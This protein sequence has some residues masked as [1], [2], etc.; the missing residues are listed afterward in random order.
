M[1]LYADLIVTDIQEGDTISDEYL[2]NLNDSDIYMYRIVDVDGQFYITYG[3]SNLT[4][5]EKRLLFSIAGDLNVNK[6][7]SSSG[8]SSNSDGVPFFYTARRFVNNNTVEFLLLVSSM[9]SVQDAVD[10]LRNQLIF[11]VVIVL[12]VSLFIS[13]LLADRISRPIDDM[14]AVAERWAKGDETVLFNGGSYTEMHE[15]ANA[16]N[17]AKTEIN[18]SGKLQRDL[19]ANVSHDLKTPLTMIKAYAEMIRD[20]S[21]ENK[22]KRDKHTQVIID[23]SDRLA[24]LV[25]DI[26]SLSKLQSQSDAPEHKIVNLSDLVETIIL[27]FDGVVLEKGYVIER[28]IDKGVYVFVD[29]KKIEEVVYNLIG[30]A[31]NYTGDDKTVKVFLSKKDNV[32]TLEIIDSGVGIS[33]DKIDTIWERYLRYS[34]THHRAVKGTGLG[35]SIVKAI[36]EAHNLEYGVVSKE[37]L[38]SNFY[39]VF[40]V[41][42]KDVVGEID[43]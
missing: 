2:T 14:S 34:E 33:D 29:E 43:G 41:L 11:V 25:N 21:G 6:I 26:L 32:A 40:N 20:I 16:L 28:H 8:E 42:S 27:R 35:L 13:F 4:Q 3:D 1:N 18:K 10:V 17:K 5:E 30:N 36:L 15:L 12:I 9:A 31:V 23:E 39:V 37:G 7:D 19:M 22:E 38:G 24:L